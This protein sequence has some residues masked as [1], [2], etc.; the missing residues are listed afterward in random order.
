MDSDAT[1]NFP[2]SDRL[3]SKSFP[4]KSRGEYQAFHKLVALFSSSI[5]ILG[6]ARLAQNK[7]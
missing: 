4:R 1:E 5:S 7:T 2:V 3:I 6:F